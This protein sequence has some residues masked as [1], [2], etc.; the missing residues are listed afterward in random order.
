MTMG[1][2]WQRDVI[3]YIE[4]LLNTDYKEYRPTKRAIFYRSVSDNMIPNLKES[5]KGLIQATSKAQKDNINGDPKRLN[6]FSFADGTRFIDDIKD[7]FWTPEQYVDRRASDLKNAS[8]GYFEGGYLTRWHGQK[9]YC[10]CMIEKNALRGAFR[11][12]LKGR[13]VRI[14][15]N[16]GWSSLVYKWT[17]IQRLVEKSNEYDNVV[18]LYFGDYDPSGVSMSNEIGEDLRASGIE[19]ERVGLN[20][21]QI[22]KYGLEHLTNPDPDVMAKLMKDPNAESFRRENDGKLFQIELDALQKDPEAFK[23]L[24]QDSVDE[25]FDE[26]INRKNHK[27][28]TAKKIDE[29]VKQKVKFL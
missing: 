21:S 4:R 24:V 17:N 19:F 3:P 26:D 6:I 28:Y 1:I 25:Y 29:L 8:K 16:N 20:H 12:A 11:N 15:P 22:S 14:V 27:K 2:N 10:E 13:E 9:N 5:Y 18:L 23:Q 7:Q